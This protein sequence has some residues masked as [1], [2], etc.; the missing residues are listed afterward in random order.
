MPG[1]SRDPILR[2]KTPVLCSNPMDVDREDSGLVLAAEEPQTLAWKDPDESSEDD[3][4]GEGCGKLGEEACFQV[5][6]VLHA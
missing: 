4:D 3:S 6:Q 5:L 1:I 2:A